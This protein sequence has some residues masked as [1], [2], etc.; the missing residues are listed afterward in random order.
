[1]G[2]YGIGVVERLKPGVRP[3]LPKAKVTRVSHHR[4]VLGRNQ[5]P[6]LDVY[7]GV[8]PLGFGNFMFC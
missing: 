6:I 5:P 4:R 1:M 8:P 7:L 2:I 3:D